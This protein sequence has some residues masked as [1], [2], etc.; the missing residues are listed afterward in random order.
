MEPLR[1]TDPKEIGPARLVARLGSGGMGTV[2]LASI[3]NSPVALKVVRGQFYEDAALKTRFQ[4]EISTMASISSPFVAE[5]VDSFV[6]EDEAWL[7]VQ[8]INGLSL[9]ERV[10]HQGPLDADE[11]WSTFVGCLTAL[12]ELH[13][14]GI[15]HRD[16][17]PGNILL[18]ES[19]PKLVDFGIAQVGEETSLTTTGLVAGT[20]AWLAPEQLEDEKLTAAADIFSLASTMVFAS[21]GSSPWGNTTTTKVPVVFNRILTETPSLDNLDS[22]R[23]EILARMLEKIPSRRPTAD[24]LLFDCLPHMPGQVGQKFEGWIS[25]YYLDRKLAT[26]PAE[27]SAARVL[28][29]LESSGN[30]ALEKLTKVAVEEAQELRKKANREAQRTVEAAKKEAARLRTEAKREISAAQTQTAREGRSVFGSFGIKRWVVTVGVFLGLNAVIFGLIFLIPTGTIF[31]GSPPPAESQDAETQTDNEGTSG[32]S[33]TPTDGE[34]LVRNSSVLITFTP[35][36]GFDN[37]RSPRLEVFAADGQPEATACPSNSFPV[38]LVRSTNGNKYEISCKFMA[39]GRYG[40]RVSWVGTN[41]GDRGVLTHLVSVSAE[42]NCFDADQWWTRCM[43]P[44]IPLPAVAENSNHGLPTAYTKITPVFG[45]DL[46]IDAYLPRRYDGI[47]ATFSA[48]ELY[49]S[50]STMVSTEWYAK[51]QQLD[52][53]LDGVLCSEATPD[54]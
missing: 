30:A 20:P 6:G 26:P 24:E 49:G 16:V 13:R 1:K 3:N 27:E 47:A 31:A 52:S 53:N 22:Y 4:R 5:V 46:L 21:S 50:P 25:L 48:R 43:K 29:A 51:L 8:F 32:F 12:S 2:Y 23:K 42:F 7:A 10:Q 33:L 44:S 38:D 39:T 18:S 37:Y 35:P 9:A 34:T 15:L 45:C 36:E 11:W 40:I 41:P 54:L 14:H 17:K 28:G 19:G